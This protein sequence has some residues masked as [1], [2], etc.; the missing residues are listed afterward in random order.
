[1]SGMKCVSAKGSPRAGLRMYEHRD[2]SAHRC[3]GK[4]CFSLVSDGTLSIEFETAV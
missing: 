1:M 2:R 4:G 3:P